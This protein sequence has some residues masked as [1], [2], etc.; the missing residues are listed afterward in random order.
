MM[1]R[2][3]Q[4]LT[5]RAVTVSMS[6]LIQILVLMWVIMNFKGYFASFYAVMSLFSAV[7]V[8]IIVNGKSNPAYK[9][10]WVIPIMLV[11][12]FGG[13]FYWIF[14]GNSLTKKDKEKMKI[15]E[16]KSKKYADQSPEALNKIG[17]INPSALAQATYIHEYAYS[18]PYEDT[19]ATYYG[20]GETL[21]EAMIE[22]LLEAKKYIFMEYFI[23]EEGEM[24]NRIL[25]ILEEKVKEGVDVRLIY[26]DIGCI[27]TLPKKYDKK[28]REKGIKVSV[29]N[30]FLPKM[31]SHFNNRDHRKI[32]V[33]D[34]QIGFT[35]GAN[36]ADEYINLYEKHGHWKDSGVRLI[37][38]AV[39][40]LTVMFLSL[41][42]YIN[43]TDEVYL[44][45]KPNYKKALGVTGFVQP[46]T[47]NPLDNEPVGETIYLNLIYKA[48]K[49]VYIKTPYLIIDNEMMM[50]L[51]SAAKSGI[52]VRI[53][54]PGVPDKWA[55]HATTRSYYE[56]LL[57]AG[58]KIYEYT[59][60]FIHE[61]TF[62]VDDLF[63]VVGTVNLDYRSLYL[64]F[65][66]GVW[67]FMTPCIDVMKADFLGMLDT[68]QC[69]TLEMCRGVKWPKRF[70]RAILRI[71]A[72]LM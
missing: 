37:G 22:A 9:I 46:F 62:V 33:V 6:I 48:T 55:V 67:L 51:C 71:F 39:Y 56:T 4:F 69:I 18:P 65:E 70:G 15:I 3:L 54:T 49:Y 1:K 36:L 23:I 57:T 42:D 30:P 47:D 38:P 44:A 58:V 16:V 28:L 50:A 20:I 5:H 11:P 68:C 72:P 14:G 21:Y 26:D 32:M 24:W 43:G 66:C 61:K 34:G 13:L 52:D 40:S 60:G 29:F 8:I 45:Y 25:E 63:G 59:P 17:R 53:I 2:G 10:A 12:I 35:G 31:S 64:H 7:V 19:D 27:L 41:W